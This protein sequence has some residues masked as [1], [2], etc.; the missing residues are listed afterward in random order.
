MCNNDI[1][2]PY[3]FARENDNIVTHIVLSHHVFVTVCIT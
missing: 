2:I 3:L 1:S